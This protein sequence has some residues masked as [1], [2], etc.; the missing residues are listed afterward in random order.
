MRGGSWFMG[1]FCSGD[2]LRALR[3][4]VVGL[5]GKCPLG[6]W[7]VCCHDALRSDLG[8]APTQLA[9]LTHPAG[10]G[11]PAGACGQRGEMQ[12]NGRLGMERAVL[13]LYRPAVC[14]VSSCVVVGAPRVRECCFC[15]GHL[16][17]DQK[18]AGEG[19]SS[20][21]TRQQQHVLRQRRDAR[22]V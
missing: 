16:A 1:S 11:Q 13:R 7:R 3:P 20:D 18:K 2:A 5:S 19:A 22:A 4:S 15:H 12:C 21:G 9:P 14:R 17:S 6:R 8:R 10:V